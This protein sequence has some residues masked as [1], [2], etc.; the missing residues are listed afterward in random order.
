MRTRTVHT[1]TQSSC[2][3]ASISRS[4]RVYHRYHHHH[5]HGGGSSK[6]NDIV[7]K[8]GCFHVCIYPTVDEDDYF[9]APLN[10]SSNC[11]YVRV[12]AYGF[13]TRRR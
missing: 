12:R 5:S 6:T 11:V 9:V 8:Q 10:A 2:S 13:L 3:G 1:C 7:T 4:K